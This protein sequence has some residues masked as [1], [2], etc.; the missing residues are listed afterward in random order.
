MEKI[1]ELAKAGA[2]EAARRMLSQMGQLLENLQ[3][4]KHL[5]SQFSSQAQQMMKVEG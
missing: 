4:G 5:P 3:T 1:R 2:R